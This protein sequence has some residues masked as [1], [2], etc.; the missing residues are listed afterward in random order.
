MLVDTLPKYCG[1]DYCKDKFKI[2]SLMTKLCWTFALLKS[3]ESCKEKAKFSGKDQK[4]EIKTKS[5][6]IV[7]PDNY[8]RKRKK[9]TPIKKDIQDIKMK[10]VRIARQLSKNAWLRKYRDQQRRDKLKVAIKK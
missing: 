2:A 5:N 1:I 6:F 7:N 3:W 10:S 9:A 4:S 8:G